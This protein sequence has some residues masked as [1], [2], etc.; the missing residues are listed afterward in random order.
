MNIHIYIYIYINMYLY[1]YMGGW[2]GGA[3]RHS[4]TSQASPETCVVRFRVVCCGLARREDG[5]Q[6]TDPESVDITE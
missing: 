3:S 6:G 5:F 2:G 1:I 4:P